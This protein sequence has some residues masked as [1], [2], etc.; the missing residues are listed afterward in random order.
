MTPKIALK[1]YLSL[2]LGSALGYLGTVFAVSLTH[3]MLIDGS[4]AAIILS[5]VPG[6]PLSVMVWSLWR[7]LK[8]SDEVVRHDLT[9]SMMIGLF[10]LLA[11]SGCWGLAELFND[12]MP[13]LPLFFAFPLFFF[14]LGI[15]SAIKF[16]RCV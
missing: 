9:Q 16:K 1:R 7:Y 15:V 10:V 3:D 2:V 13:R 11:L 6:V 12:S 4:I 14:I 5:L 8:E